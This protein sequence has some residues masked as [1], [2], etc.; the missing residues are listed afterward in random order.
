MSAA[1][2]LARARI[3]AAR[4]FVDACTIQRLA[5]ST[6][7]PDT[8]AVVRTYTTIYAGP[9][10]IQN[11]GAAFARPADVGQAEVFLTR[12]ELHVPVTA[13][14]A[15]PDDLLTVTASAHDADMVGRQWH[16]RGMPDKSWPTAH[17]YSIELVAG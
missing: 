12:M 13:A 6:S 7:D 8:G 5:T 2:V 14:V 1:S 4:L 10:K 11:S 16:I 17:R 9:C 3:A 15:Q